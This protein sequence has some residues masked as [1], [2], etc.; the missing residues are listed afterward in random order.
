MILNMIEYKPVS[1]ADQV[2]DRLEN[3]ILTGIYQKGETLTEQMLCTE[4]GVSRTPVREALR[5]L[6]QEHLI[7]THSRGMVVVGIGREDAHLLFEIRRRIEGLAAA[8]CARNATEEQLMQMKEFIDLQDFYSE[9]SESEKIK[10][11][12]GSFHELIYRAAGSAVIYDVLLPLHKKLLKFRRNS[13]SNTGRAAV[14]AK[15][16]RA[17][18]EAIARRDER[19]A[20]EAMLRHVNNAQEH[21]EKNTLIP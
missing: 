19:G 20:E 14:S 11:L 15:E 3:D 8:A 5:R 1:L 18:Y 12:D 9:K 13:L 4:L 7:E 17:I 10:A 16:H 2:F 21:F 6:E